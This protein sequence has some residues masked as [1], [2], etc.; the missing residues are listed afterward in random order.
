MWLDLRYAENWTLSLDLLNMWG[1]SMPFAQRGVVRRATLRDFL[2]MKQTGDEPGETPPT[3][4]VQPEPGLS[5][6]TVA[7]T[8][9]A[10]GFGEDLAYYRQVLAEFTRRFPHTVV[11]VVEG[12]PVER[13]PDVPMRPDYVFWVFERNRTLAGNLKYPGRLSV[14]T[15]GTL[16]RILREDADVRIVIE[17]TPTALLSWATG[18]LRRRR[19]VLLIEGDPTFRGSA[20]RQVTSWIKR[21]VA[22]RAHAVLTS[23]SQGERYLTEVLRLPPQKVVV[24]PYL[25]SDPGV[26]PSRSA[27]GPVR[28]LFLN[29]ISRRKGILELIEALAA[30]P[31]HLSERWTLQVVGSGDLEHEVR[32]LVVERG[33]ASQV[34][35]HDRVPHAETPRFYGGAEIVVCPTLRDYRSLAGIEAVNAGRG[36]LVSTRDG[37]ADEIME[38]AAAAWL[39]DPLDPARFIDVLTE[40]L[41]DVEAVRQ[42]LRLAVRPPHAFS[43]EVVGDSLQRAVESALL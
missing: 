33:L 41:S 27:H 4:G 10:Y 8:A 23:N 2:M 32:G 40:M 11:H 37:A 34:A 12:Y 15:P 1:P 26:Q 36:V 25:T 21:Q 5:S 19:V 30:L 35:F 28:L 42:R 3:S 31:P 17:F 7:W 20:P 22:L 24:G 43:L 18:L 16:L 14:P 6:T 38:N 13:Y 9:S 29:T 39:V